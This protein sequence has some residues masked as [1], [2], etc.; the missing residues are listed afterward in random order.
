MTL[1]VQFVLGGGSHVG[2]GDADAVIWSS[3]GLLSAPVINTE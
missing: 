2:D 3:N 1:K